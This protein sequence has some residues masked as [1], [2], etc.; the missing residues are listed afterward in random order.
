MT[1]DQYDS[2]LNLIFCIGFVL[3]AVISEGW[4]TVLFIIG[5]VWSGVDHAYAHK[6]VRGKE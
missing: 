6:R 3:L 4:W 5:A 2:L 1:T